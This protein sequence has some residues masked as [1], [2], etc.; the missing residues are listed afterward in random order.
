MFLSRRDFIAS[1][2]AAT[3][4][5]LAESGHVVLLGDSIFDNKVYLGPNEP[6]TIDRL[7]S[8]LPAGWKGTLAAVDG[9]VTADIAAQLETI[10]ADA[11]HLVI[12][13]GGN[14]ALQAQGVLAKA[15]ANV[16]EALV[17]LGEVRAGFQA[18]YGKM[19]DGVLKLNKPTVLCTIY[20]PRFPEKPRQAAAKMGLI[21][22]NDVITR[23]AV[24]RG[25]PLLD[26]RVLFT[27]A[28]D[29]ANAIEPSSAG[30][31][32]IA[33]EIIRI[34]REHDFAK[35]RTVVYGGEA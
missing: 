29:Y 33:K 3:N 35:R 34:L 9:D 20:D 21:A 15:V 22:Y 32:K 8:E 23:T 7:R 13:V 27:E 11:S 5:V 4:T 2:T 25:L 10:P 6:A 30:S 28:S 16:A 26:L 14:D 18:A 12:S 24:S 17:A 19:L 1:A 31:L